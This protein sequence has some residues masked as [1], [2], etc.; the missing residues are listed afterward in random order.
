[1]SKQPTSFFT[2]LLW[3]LGVQIVLVLY[4]PV[5][6]YRWQLREKSKNNK[7]DNK[8]SRSHTG[9]EGLPFPSPRINPRNIN[10]TFLGYVWGTSFRNIVFI[11]PVVAESVPRSCFGDFILIQWGG[12]LRNKYHKSRHI[13]P[14][15]DSI[16]VI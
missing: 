3:Y 1:M 6:R 2:Y 5:L 9:H 15:L 13:N 7:H 8:C 10:G 11:P 4:P 14:N 16:F 12:N